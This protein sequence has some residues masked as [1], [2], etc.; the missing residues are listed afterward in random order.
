VTAK[1]A[2]DAIHRRLGGDLDALAVYDR[3]VRSRFRS[4]N[5]FSLVLQAFAA[6]PRMLDHALRRLERRPDVRATL[7][8]A[9]TDQAP[10]SDA[11]DPR[12]LAR[13]VAP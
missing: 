12:F 8:R 4:K 13:L 3:R 9:L 5:V 1:L 7:T 11:L 2:A 6:N 10:A